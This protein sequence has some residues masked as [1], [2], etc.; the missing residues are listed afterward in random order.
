MSVPVS[1]SAN[2]PAPIIALEISLTLI[3][4]GAAFAWP[5]LRS[6]WFSR[7]ESTL[8]C[9]ASRK[10]LAVFIVGISVILLRLLL[11]PRLPIPLPFVHDDFSFLLAADT[12]AHGR[13]TNPTPVMW[14]HFE[15]F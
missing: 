2:G 11:L 6:T 8:A 7:I 3:S 10:R 13:L 4:V 14:P 15:S 12:F 5:E 9:L 1:L